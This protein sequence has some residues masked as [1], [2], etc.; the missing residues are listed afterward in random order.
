[1][2]RSEWTVRPHPHQRHAN[3]RVGTMLLALAIGALALAALVNQIAIVTVRRAQAPP[4][5]INTRTD[6]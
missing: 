3:P 2:A 4:N 1:V 5:A 6:S